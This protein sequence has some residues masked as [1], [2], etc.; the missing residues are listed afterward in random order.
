LDVRLVLQ[1]DDDALIAMTYRGVR[2]GPV[3]TIE[4]LGKG[5]EVHPNRLLLQ[6]HSSVP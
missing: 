3:D 4:R 2:H 1:T 6:N 5:E